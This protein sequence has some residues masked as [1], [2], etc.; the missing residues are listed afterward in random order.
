[1]LGHV[2]FH[3]L[4][5]LRRLFRGPLGPLVEK[6]DVVRRHLE[7]ARAHISRLGRFLRVLRG[8]R[9]PQKDD[10]HATGHKEFFHSLLLPGSIS[11]SLFPKATQGTERLAHQELRVPRDEIVG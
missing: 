5:D 6:A 11:D 1:M 10:C 3:G 9:G 4:P 2:A 7:A 8:E